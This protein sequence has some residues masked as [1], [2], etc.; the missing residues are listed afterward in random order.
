MWRHLL[1]LPGNRLAFKALQ[2]QGEHPA[3]ARLH[4]TLGPDERGP[5]G[6]CAHQNGRM[7]R[8]LPTLTLTLTLTLT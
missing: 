3:F 7:Q 8:L 5:N 6:R 4:H 2:E 1:Q